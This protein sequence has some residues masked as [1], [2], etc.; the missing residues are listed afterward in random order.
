VID[1]KTNEFITSGNIY[2][3]QKILAIIPELSTNDEWKPQ[4]PGGQDQ[5]IVSIISKNVTM[6]DLGPNECVAIFE[7]CSPVP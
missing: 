4:R 7:D 3:N 6:K 2:K 1:K 5:S